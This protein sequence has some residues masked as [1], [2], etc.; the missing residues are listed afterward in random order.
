[1]ER[2]ILPSPRQL[3]GLRRAV[4]AYPRR[5][6]DEVAGDVVLALDEAATNAVLHGSGG[7]SR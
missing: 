2:S 4:R 6:P 1:M 5:L 3:A 7:G